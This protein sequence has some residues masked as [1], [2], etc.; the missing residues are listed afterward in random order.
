[1][2]IDQLRTFLAVLEH[3]SFSRAAE[4]LR[5][6]QSTISFHIK[7]LETAVGA[8]VLDRHGGQVRPTA[9]GAVLR[10][11]AQR[12]VSLRDEAL[13]KLRAEES[14]QA[15]R[16]T[17]AASTIP[18]EY[19]LPPVLAE[20]LA[21]HPNVA[22]TVE[23]S[24]SRKALVQ[25]LAHECDLAL[26]GA[27]ARDKRILYTPF[28]EDEVVLVGRPEGPPGRRKS[29]V[30]DLGRARIVV[31]E[32]GSGTRQ[33]VA[34]FLAW[35]TSPH[36]DQ[37]PRLQGGGPRRPSSAARSTAS[38][39]PCSRDRR[40]PRISTRAGWRSCPHPASRCAA[41]STWRGC[42]RRRSRRRPRRCAISSFRRI[43]SEY[44]ENRYFRLDCRVPGTYQSLQLPGGLRCHTRTDSTTRPPRS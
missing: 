32:E 44:L 34:A 3:G 35:H 20:F 23:V 10:R 1:M 25:L 28:A 9:T 41:S 17:I 6:G 18:A 26:V 13:A 24:D 22:V 21:A 2:D 7:A 39:W 8:R 19:L 12:I 5:V 42:A 31:R 43:D 27:R 11:Y 29:V 16:L 33:A 36:A 37:V 4:A 40:S 15:G 38:A 30:R 14:G